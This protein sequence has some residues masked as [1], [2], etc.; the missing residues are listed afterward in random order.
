M[1]SLPQNEISHS[2]DWTAA[3]QNIGW[4]SQLASPELVEAWMDQDAYAS[5]VIDTEGLV[6]KVNKTF[7]NW[8][9]RKRAEV[10]FQNIKEVFSKKAYHSLWEGLQVSCNGEIKVRQ[11]YPAYI[12]PDQDCDQVC[13]NQYP[14]KDAQKGEV[15][16]VLLC[17]KLDCAEIPAKKDR[18][19]K[20]GT[21]KI[22][23]SLDTYIV[24]VD[25][26]MKILAYNQ[27][28]FDFNLKH[29]P[30]EVEVGMPFLDLVPAE[31]H[32]K[33]AEPFKK[34]LKGETVSQELKIKRFWC[35]VKHSPVYQDDQIIAVL[36]SIVK[37]EDWVKMRTEFKLL[38]QE[39]MRSNV[40][41]QQFA[42]ITSHNLRAPV[43]NLVSLLGFIDRK[44]IGDSMNQ[45]IFH[46][47]DT[48]ALRLESTLQ[49]LVQVV[50]IK[51]RREVVF[52]RVNFRHLLDQLLESMSYQLIESET[53][54]QADFTQIREVIYPYNYLWSICQNLLSNAMKYKRADVRPEINITSFRED[55][56]VGIRVSDNGLGMDLETYGDRLFGLYQRFHE[57]DG[58]KGKGLGLY[59]VKSQVE[60]L[61]GRIEVESKVN[62]GSC[63]SIYLQ[64][65]RPL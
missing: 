57:G 21:Q 28:F 31:R 23:D 42:Y 34:A 16:G 45:Q 50:A 12:F 1:L 56:Y 39:L 5:I 26:Q 36:I 2:A 60:S 54:I 7:L 59:V 14:L 47:V 15:I 63:F 10:L 55:G 22:L 58:L 35:E 25:P 64:K 19:S 11:T 49:D 3:N 33:Y 53:M 40:E 61:D 32:E 17:M 65:L 13:V 43:V 51:E 38:T 46:K 18:P 20:I 30:I 62:Q 41:L 6:H 48:S 52:S 27:L 9:N 24:V 4:L 8:K 37:I 29:F 44:Q